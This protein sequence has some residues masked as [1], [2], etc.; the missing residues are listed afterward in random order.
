MAAIA[1]SELGGPTG[2]PSRCEPG[3]PYATG[4]MVGPTQAYVDEECPCECELDNPTAGYYA[5]LFPGCAG[6]PDITTGELTLKDSV[7]L[8]ARKF[9]LSLDYNYHS[10]HPLDGV[11]GRGRSMSVGGYI[12][13]PTDTTL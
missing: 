7:K 10:P 9:G 4:G 3:A 1:P 13:S 2:V 8:T 11:Y 6:V 12:A 5:T